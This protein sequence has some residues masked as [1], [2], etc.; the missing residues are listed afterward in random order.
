MNTQPA[1]KNQLLVSII[2]NNYNYDRF[3]PEAIDSALNQTYPH[4]EV[5]VVDDGSTDNSRTVIAEYGDRI[6]PIL[7]A[8]G[9]QGAAFNSGFAKSRGDLILFLDADDYLLP[10]AVKQIVAAWK[11]GIAKI[12]YRLTVVDGARHALGFSYPPANRCLANGNVQQHLLESGGYTSTPTSG[13]AYARK[14]LDEVFPIPQAYSQ[15]ADDYLMI[16]TPFSGDLIGIEEPLAAYRIHT[17][18]QWALATVSGDRFRR[19]VHHDL[20]NY[21]LLMQKAKERGFDVPEDLERRSLGRLWSRL[22]SLRLDPREHPVSSDNPL[23]LT[24]WGLRALW[25]YSDHNLPKRLIY[26]IWFF[27]VGFMPVPL[28]KPAISWLYAPHLRP[29]PI[30]WTLTQLRSLVS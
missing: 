15:T 8:N 4:V 13:N 2:V 20:Q 27:W 14:T 23:S 17:S 28:A 5:I 12:H 22:A 9:K 30:D 25:K 19:F 11:P 26:T 3:L 6:I 18:N 24:L 29:K 10:H 7:Q 16:L 21:A 1:T